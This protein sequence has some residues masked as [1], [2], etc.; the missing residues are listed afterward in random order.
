[1]GAGL[2]GEH[3]GLD[4]DALASKKE[5]E[6]LRLEVGRLRRGREQERELDQG[7]LHAELDSLKRMVHALSLR[8][9]DVADAQAEGGGAPPPI[10]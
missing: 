8:L 4:V 6:A 7:A 10:T 1:M 2:P 3:G 9:A 5:L